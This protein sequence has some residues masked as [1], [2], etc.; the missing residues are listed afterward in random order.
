MHGP[1]N[2]KKKQKHSVSHA[3]SWARPFLGPIQTTI[4]WV[5]G[6][7]Y[8]TSVDS[9]LILIFIFSH[10]SGLYLSQT[11]SIFKHLTISVET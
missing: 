3:D 2:I 1:M 7:L 6:T 8:T 9:A 11:P 10:V 4:Q 5:S